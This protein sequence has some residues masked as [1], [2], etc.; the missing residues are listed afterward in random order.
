MRKI[1]L[2]LSGLALLLGAQGAAAYD[3]NCDLTNAGGTTA[4][5][6]AVVL[7]GTENITSTFDGYS[8]G[9]FLH[10]HFHNV[11]HTPTAAGDT[12]I[13]WMNME[14][15]DS[16]IPPGKTI[17]VGWQSEDCKSTIKDMYWTDKYHRRIRGS[18][19]HDTSHGIFY[20]DS[21]W[22]VLNLGNWLETR[23]PITVRNLRFAVVPRA[24]PLA[25]L[26]SNNRELVASL[27]PVSD[28]A[29]TLA[30]GQ[31]VSVAIPAAVEPDQAVVAFFETGLEGSAARVGNFVQQV[32]VLNGP[33]SFRAI[34][35]PVPQQ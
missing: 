34:P 21:R 23:V 7:S 11:T 16:P 5:D 19:V 2:R 8:D 31:E 32:N 6:I 25:A 14:G 27:R 10:G 13:H 9:S 35:A 22:P 20:R 33:C 30:P 12:V 1:A 29:I 26:A 28:A 24:L 15:N 17:H 4:Y 18:V 3:Y